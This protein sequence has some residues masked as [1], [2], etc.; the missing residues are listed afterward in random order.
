MFINSD[1]CPSYSNAMETQGY[2]KGEPEK[3]TTH[4]AVDD[5]NDSGGYFIAYRFP[6]TRPMTKIS[7]SGH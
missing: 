4:P 6:V 3:W 5:Y 7:M 2:E 1:E